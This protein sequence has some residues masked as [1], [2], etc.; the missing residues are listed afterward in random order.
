MAFVGAPGATA[1]SAPPSPLRYTKLFDALWSTVDDHFYDPWFRGV[2]WQAV[3][4]RYRRKLDGVTNDR[5]FEALAT[6]MLDELGTS[7]LYVE[8]PSSSNAAGVGIGVRFRTIGSQI[9][10]SALDPLSN[11]RVTG[12]RPGDR[13]L[14]PQSALYGE[15][16]TTAMLKVQSCAGEFRTLDVKREGAFWPPQHPGFEWHEVALS[17]H[18]KVGYIKIDRFDD[19]AA[20]LADRAMAELKDTSALII[21]VRDNSGGN[22]SAT[23]LAS[24]FI[25]GPPRVEL[26]LFS[27]AYL[28]MLGHP[29]TAADVAAAPKVT[30]AYTDKAI[31]AAVAAHHGGA[32]F[33]TEDM[34]D[35]R[36]A[37]PVVVLIGEDTGSA[38]EGFA[39]VMRDFTKATLVGRKTA[40]ALLSAETFDLP[41]DWKVTV[42]VQGV[43]GPDGTDFRDRAASPNVT[44]NWTRDDLCS[45][46]DPDIA[47]ALRLLSSSVASHNSQ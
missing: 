14:S 23:R 6:R 39:W 15:P 46:R 22:L 27:R 16:G 2:N 43:W 12:L 41:D 40:G 33:M 37:K 32:V 30:G 42:P 31:F 45:G 1:E 29:V 4:A 35:K 36:Y 17:P 9:L 7:H 20:E 25:S 19:G 13:L 11:A 3:G 8:P 5:R 28:K 21:D 18:R 47:E 44:V 10:V 24:Y 38:A 34:G 26:A